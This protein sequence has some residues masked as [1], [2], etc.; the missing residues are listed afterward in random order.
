VRKRIAST[1]VA[2][3]L[4]LAGCVTEFPGYRGRPAD[5]AGDAAPA[6]A[7][8]VTP[9][10]R[11]ADAGVRDALPAD[12]TVADA[13]PADARLP[14]ALPVDALR[15]DARAPDAAAPDASRDATVADAA[16]DAAV[17]DAASPEAAVPDAADLDA[18]SADAA[19]PDA[20]MTDAAAPD[21]AAPDA[22]IP[23][24]AV[25][26]AAACAPVAETCNGVD[27]DCD[28]RVDEDGVCGP[29]VAG[30]CRVWLGWADNLS[31][32][33]GPSA[34]WGDCPASDSHQISQVRCTSTRQDG[35]FRELSLGGDVDDNDQLGVAFTCQ[36]AAL[37]QIAAWTQAHCAVYLAHA[38]V[39]LGFDDTPEWGPC[40]AAVQGDN[41][42]LRCTSSGFDGLYHPMR[43]V[44]NVNE[45][46]D[47]AVAF[48]CR[49]FVDG[50]RATNVQSSAQVFFAWDRFEELR[51]GADAW[52]G[53]PAA[54]RVDDGNARCVS[55]RGDGWFHKIDLDGNVDLIDVFGIA[56]K[57]R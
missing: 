11:I 25:P 22:S 41:G 6:D 45:D 14:D 15:P 16:V 37:P 19:L 10:A 35:R 13:R 55:S 24:A 20:A 31:G 40:P 42:F 38:D 49:D 3:A 5:A 36:D 17:S 53:C 44:G 50:D 26:D 33:A 30:H 57:A 27:D 34:T 48:I 4:V 51:D 12:V 56:L 32:P 54:D 9:D 52:G 28:G 47:V 46:D 2:P 29:W 18:L 7:H 1:I 43:L 39:N 23:D 8:P 21:A